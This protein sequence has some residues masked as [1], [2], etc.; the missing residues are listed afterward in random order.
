ME[1]QGL[2]QHPPIDKPQ[3]HRISCLQLADAA[4]K[5]PLGVSYQA[6]AAAQGAQGGEGFQEPLLLLQTLPLTGEQSAGMQISEPF[7]LV[8]ESLM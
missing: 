1:T 7:L 6:I 8:L 5:P 3:I 4:D 2:G